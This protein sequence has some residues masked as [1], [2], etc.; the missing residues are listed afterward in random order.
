MLP[1]DIL[2]LIHAMVDSMNEYSDLPSL[3]A[4]GKLV[5]K[6][7]DFVLTCLGEVLAMTLPEVDMM[8][9]R[10]QTNSSI[11]ISSQGGRNRLETNFVYEFRIRNEHLGTNF[12]YEIRLQIHFAS[13]IS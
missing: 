12:V 2:A 13:E 5:D 8:R 7:N 1:E 9:F 11:R 3:R 6:T 10:L 4:I